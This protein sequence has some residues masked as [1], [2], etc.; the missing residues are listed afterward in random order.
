MV[1]VS[2]EVRYGAA[3]FGVRVRASSIRRAVGLAKAFCCAD[4]VAVVFP[5]E[6]EGFF[7][8]DPLAT[9]GPIETG[10]PRKKQQAA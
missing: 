3:R 8:E 6:P 5:I 10:K 9:E 2:I 7:V 4:E 1:K